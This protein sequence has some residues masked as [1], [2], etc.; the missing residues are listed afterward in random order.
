M[1]RNVLGAL[2][3]ATCG[4]AWLRFGFALLSRLSPD[5][6]AWAL[7]G[8]YSRPALT[9][10]FSR[11][12][13]RLLREAA[14]LMAEAE[15]IDERT[16]TKR[17][18]QRLRGYLFRAEAERRGLALLLHGWTAD[19]RAMAAFVGPLVAAG[20]DALAVD[21]PAH[22]R[23]SGAVTDAESGAA[24]VRALLEAR[25]LHPDHVIAHSFGGAVASV[26]A[27]EGVTPRAFVSLAA[28]SAMAAALEEL[29][30][31]LGLT[32][33]ARARLLARAARAAGRPLEEFDARRIWAGRPTSILV[34][35]APE[36]GSVSYSHA[37]RFR[38]APNARILP[39]PGIGHREIV[40]HASAVEAAVDHILAV[41]R[42]RPA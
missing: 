9:R 42:V 30:D 35:H 1:T 29:A 23:S 21:L 37:E 18:V 20:Y 38:E 11:A 41:D 12:E 16:P 17:G 40:G 7:H 31:A 34:V 5:A 14:R 10:K 36:D 24:A 6:A 32:P 25:G 15:R 28:P 22:G 26:L 19:S 27:A 3:A 39:A 8:L 2:S 13:R 33:A 4:W